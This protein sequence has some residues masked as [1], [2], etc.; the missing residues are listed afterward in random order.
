MCKNNPIYS[1]KLSEIIIIVNCDTVAQ[2]F[3][4]KLASPNVKA[5]LDWVTIEI[6]LT[7]VLSGIGK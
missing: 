6:M 3:S 7:F 2:S 5:P 1:H 4:L